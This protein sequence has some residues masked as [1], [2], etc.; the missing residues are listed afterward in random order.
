MVGDKSRTLEA[1]EKYSTRVR[2]YGWP[3]AFVAQDGMIPADVPPCSVVFLGGTYKWK[4][5]NAEQ[6]ASFPRLHIGRVN[7]LGKL[8]RCEELGVE[9]VDGT[10]WFRRPEKEFAELEEFFR[11]EPPAQLPLEWNKQK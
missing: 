7:T 11:G 6:F 10:G 1:W 2:A 8:R 3:V 9:S 5:R 4:W